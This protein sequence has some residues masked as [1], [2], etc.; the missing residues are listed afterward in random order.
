MEKLEK[1]RGYQ[2][3]LLYFD[4]DRDKTNKYLM[5]KINSKVINFDISKEIKVDELSE[6]ELIKEM[7][8]KIEKKITESIEKDNNIKKNS[9]VLVNLKNEMF[10]KSNELLNEEI[11]N[12]KKEFEQSLKTE[13][14]IRKQKVEDLNQNSQNEQKQ[15]NENKQ[16]L[17]EK[18]EKSME[19]SSDKN[20]SYMCQNYE[21]NKI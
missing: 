20:P 2:N 21:Y 10:E 13:N 3:I 19:K 1:T 17:Q 12:K 8:G 6:K 9:K 4:G 18:S 15:I 14:E 7:A 11:A 16:K 5:D